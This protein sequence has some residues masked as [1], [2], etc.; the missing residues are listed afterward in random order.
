MEG[1]PTEINLKTSRH[2]QANRG[3]QPWRSRSTPALSPSSHRPPDPPGSPL[4]PPHPP[5][6]SRPETPNSRPTAAA[7]HRPTPPRSSPLWNARPHPAGA[8][9]LSG[10]SWRVPVT[11][12]RRGR[13][14]K[15][16]GSGRARSGGRAGRRGGGG[17]GAP[18][19]WRTRSRCTRCRA[20]P[21]GERPITPAPPRRRGTT[22]TGVGAAWRGAAVPPPPPPNPLKPPHPPH[23]LRAGGAVCAPRPA[24]LPL[25]GSRTQPGRSAGRGDGPPCRP[26]SGVVG[27]PCLGPGLR[28]PGLLPRTPVRS[29]AGLWWW[30][31][32]VVVPQGPEALPLPAPRVRPW[33]PPPPHA[34]GPPATPRSSGPLPAVYLRAGCS[35]WVVKRAVRELLR[36]G[37]ENVLK[38]KN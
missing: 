14:R 8:S 6:T 4:F 37:T 31:R 17:G 32:R 25:R 26:R 13:R 22:G 2:L 11:S 21:S 15:R 35:P 36:V 16:R 24:P 29:P 28:R 5:G 9:S 7:S 10:V 38:R 12:G 30:W 34:G 27:S 33:L 18:P 1:D 3:Q 19:R 20:A 23:L